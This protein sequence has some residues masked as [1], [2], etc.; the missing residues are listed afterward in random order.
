MSESAQGNEIIR[1][2]LVESDQGPDQLDLDLVELEQCGA[3]AELIGRVFRCVHT[4]KGTRYFLGFSR[5]E[6]VAHVRELRTPSKAG[7]TKPTA[8]ISKR[9]SGRNHC[10]SVRKQIKVPAATLAAATLGKSCRS[11]RIGQFD[12]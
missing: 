10:F 9:R 5:L 8:E 12:R 6:S 11:V 1:K 2:I 3:N 4:T 7:A